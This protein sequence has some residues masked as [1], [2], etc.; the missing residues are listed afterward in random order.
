MSSSLYNHRSADFILEEMI[1]MF[2][3]LQPNVS[4]NEASSL[5]FLFQMFAFVTAQNNDMALQ[6]ANAAFVATAVD[7]DLTDL[8]ADRGVIRKDA[9]F[10]TVLLEL[11]RSVVGDII[12]IPA[13]S[14]FSTQADNSG[15]SAIFNT[16]STLTIPATSESVS[17]Y[18]FSQTGGVAGNVGIN[19]I[20]EFISDIPGVDTVTNPTEGIGGVDI[21]SDEALR[22][23]LVDTLANNT[24]RVTTSGYR[25]FLESLDGVKSATVEAASGAMPNYI[26]AVVT[27]T[28]TDTGIPTASQLSTWETEINKDEN[29]AVV[30]VIDVIAPEEVE[31]TVTATID[32]Y[33]DGAGETSTIERV[34]ESIINFINALESG[35]TVRVNDIANIIHDD[36]AVVDYTLSAPLSNEELT[37]L[38]K[39]TASIS[40][41]TIT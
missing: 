10:A 3:I 38:Q 4:V 5:Y 6:F 8:A 12:T 30:D 36:S 2:Q 31:I 40:T 41:V 37:T 14:S 26:T 29:R 20:I 18:A 33:V 13:S 1:S 17:G 23:R 19:S 9:E 39:A 21:E 34:Q 25:Q 16:F 15:Q 32:T 7:D 22:E 28:L 27:T 35:G 11:S 24:G